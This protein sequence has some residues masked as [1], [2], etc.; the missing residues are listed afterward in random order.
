MTVMNFNLIQILAQSGERIFD[1]NAIEGVAAKIGISSSYIPRLLGQESKRGS[2][3]ALGKGFYSLPAEL[4]AGG[5]LHSFEIA[6]KLSGIGAIS[7][8][9]AMAY[10][11]LT[12]QMIQT[13]Y[14]TV[15]KQAGANHSTIKRYTLRGQEYVLTRIHPDHYWGIQSIFIEEAKVNV[16]DLERTLID[17]LSHP[18]ICGGFREVLYAFE[19]AEDKTSEERFLEYT[20][21][22][23]LIVAKRLGWVLE[24][25]NLHQ[26][27]QKKLL[28][29][30]V[31]YYQKLDPSGKRQGRH[32]K[33]WMLMENVV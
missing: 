31:S 19:M 17:G 16:T 3:V 6:M 9:S 29:I 27:L 22:T 30:P 33:R 21:R 26:N 12:D 32:N 24:Q 28:D 20:K 11:H 4:L 25:L 23:S 10:Y 18:N 7:H 5:P 14:V 1:K 13:T 15:P 2:L 8:H